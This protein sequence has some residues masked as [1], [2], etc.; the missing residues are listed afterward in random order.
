MVK[1]LKVSPNTS[2]QLSGHFLY[3]KRQHPPARHLRSFAR[4]IPSNETP[5]GDGIHIFST[6]VWGNLAMY[7]NNKKHKIVSCQT[8]Q[9]LSDPIKNLSLVISTLPI[10]QTPGVT[11]SRIQW[12]LTARTVQ[13][14]SKPRPGCCI[15]PKWCLVCIDPNSLCKLRLS[16]KMYYILRIFFVCV[17]FL[18]LELICRWL[19]TCWKKFMT[20]LLITDRFLPEAERWIRPASQTT[21]PAHF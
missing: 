16:I 17:Q 20:I 11:L 19:I 12:P 2:T 6:M 7:C 13:A 9:T 1:P 5:P 21:K 3:L 18:Q 14:S 15:N 4:L 10:L 8:Y